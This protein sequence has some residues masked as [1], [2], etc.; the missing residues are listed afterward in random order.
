M[1]ILRTSDVGPDDLQSTRRLVD[2]LRALMLAAARS[3]AQPDTLSAVADRVDELTKVLEPA[4][5]FGALRIAIDAPI[6]AR[7]DELPLRTGAYSAFAIPMEMTF[8]ADGTSARAEFV[9]NALH[10]GPPTM[11][12]GGIIAWVF[13]VVLGVLV[14]AQGEGAFTKSLSVSYLQPTPLEAPLIAEARVMS[15]NGRHT[16]VEAN[17][18]ATGIVTARAFGEFVVPRRLLRPEVGNAPDEAA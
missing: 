3:S 9:A 6:C 4:G 15:V 17:L 18:S 2:S 11:M 14:Q 13:D 7:R 8:A 16:E 10:E 1:R 5:R 12:H